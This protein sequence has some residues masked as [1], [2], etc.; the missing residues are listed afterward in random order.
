MARQ[1]IDTGKISRAATHQQPMC[2]RS[3]FYKDTYKD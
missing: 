3:V 1:G 2:G